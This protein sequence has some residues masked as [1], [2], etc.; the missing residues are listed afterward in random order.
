MQTIT[1]VVKI[2]GVAM[3][4]CIAMPVFAESAPVFDADAVQQQLDNNDQGQQEYPSPPPP[5]DTS[6]APEATQQQQTEFQA[7]P[8]TVAVESSPS[9]PSLSLSARVRKV[10]Q[11]ITNMQTTDS[12]ARVEQLQN[13]IQA[14]RGQVEALQHQLQQAQ[15]QQKS[16]YEDL[17]KRLAS[18][19]TNADKP[20]LPSPAPDTSASNATG[21][22]PIAAPLPGK[23][24]KGKTQLAKN[25]KQS[26]AAVPATAAPAAS[27]ANG[28]PS[29]AEE[30]QAYQTVYN[31]IKAKKYSDA[32]NV[33]QTML[34][35]YPSGQFASNAHYWLGELYSSMGK[36]DPALTEFNS[37]VKSYPDSPRVSEAQLKVGL[38]LASQLKWSDARLAFKSVV[39]HYPGTASAQVA[40]Q[41]LKQLKQAG[42]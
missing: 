34:K 38:I 31:M 16:M 25:A 12:S 29:L 28:Q 1:R 5:G 8:S 40:S 23:G 39:S 26:D 30:Q 19:A 36:T 20:S 7:G 9:T 18:Q 2:V 21:T 41:Q 35:K 33:L 13:Q 37:V 42:H 4:L 17:D 22:P 15:T 6:F 14:L 11:Q 3:T 27:T 24:K 10:E 32:V